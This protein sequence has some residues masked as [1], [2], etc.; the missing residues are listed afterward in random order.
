MQKSDCVRLRSP[1]PKE[2]N[3]LSFRKLTTA[4][5]GGDEGVEGKDEQKQAW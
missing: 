1:G 4:E 3:G 2:R 5:R